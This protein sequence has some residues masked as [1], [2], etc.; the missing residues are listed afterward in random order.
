MKPNHKYIRRQNEIITSFFMFMFL[1]FSMTLLAQGP[2][3]FSGKWEF[4]KAASDKDEVG[5]SSFNGRIIMEIKLNSDS[6]SF[7][8]TYFIP[9]KDEI[10]M[11]ADSYLANGKVSQDNSGTD[12]A[13][14]FI[15]WS[16]DKNILKTNITMTASVDGVAQDFITENTYKLSENGKI[17]IVEEL[18]KSN[19]GQRTVKKIYNKK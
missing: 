17:L 19:D 15:K 14:K 5:E 10:K 8:H 1:L 16:Q 12:P 11:P 9:G 4:D 3:N 18:S 2:S 7:T 6:I 13:K